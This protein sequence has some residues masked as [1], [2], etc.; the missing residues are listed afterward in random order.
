MPRISPGR[1]WWLALSLFSAL[2]LAGCHPAA[3]VLPSYIQNVGVEVFQ[4]R[5]SEFGLE[6]L[7][8]QRTLQQFQMDGRM[9]IEDPSRADLVVRAVITRYVEEPLMYDPKTNFV[10]QYRI[11]LVYDLAAVDQKEK[12]TIVEDKDKIHSVFYYSPE[13]NGAIV[14]TKQEAIA[15]LGEDMAR[16]IVRRVLEGY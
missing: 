6:T 13:Y 14:E 3:L 5:T 16:S 2:F 1:R 10:L 7:L 11:S 4:N 8:T 15:R 9:Q 12:R